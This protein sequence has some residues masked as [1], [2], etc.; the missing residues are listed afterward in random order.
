MGKT[1]NNLT[2]I[3]FGLPGKIFRSPLP[4]GSF[5]HG[6]TTMDEMRA[7]KISKTVVLVEEFE[8]WQRANCD[9]PTLY[10][11]HQIEMFHYPVVDFNVPE[12]LGSYLAAVQQVLAWAKSGENIAIHCFAGIG[13]TGTFLTAMAVDVF[14]WNPLEAVLWIRQFVPGAVENETQFNFVMQSFQ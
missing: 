12:D 11:G 13:R 6:L 14:G 9:L 10:Q 2:L 5:D 4:G 1:M 7:E 3:P 8:W